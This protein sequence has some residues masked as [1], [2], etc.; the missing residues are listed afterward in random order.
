MTK[1]HIREIALEIVEEILLSEITALRVEVRS[2]RRHSLETLEQVRAMRL[3]FRNTMDRLTRQ[4][5][6]LTK[7]VDNR[8]AEEENE[9]PSSTLSNFLGIA[10]WTASSG[11]GMPASFNSELSAAEMQTRLRQMEHR[12]SI[13]EKAL[14]RN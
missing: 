1:T 7:I 12:L 2:L 3:E 11:S 4:L 9:K 5:E 8:L 13:I 6:R 10:N 14:Q